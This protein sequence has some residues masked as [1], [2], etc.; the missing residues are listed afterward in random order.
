VSLDGYNQELVMQNINKEMAQDI[1]L[2]YADIHSGN[3][4]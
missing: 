2:S 4:D 3:I 1:H